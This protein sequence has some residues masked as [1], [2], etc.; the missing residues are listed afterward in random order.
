LFFLITVFELILFVSGLSML[1]HYR[2][3]TGGTLILLAI[4]LFFL[5]SFRYLAR[6]RAPLSCCGTECAFFEGLACAECLD[7]G[8]GGM[9]CIDCGVMDCGN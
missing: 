1:R 4:I 5:T 7:T 8:A 6:Q 2:A 9:D 3:G